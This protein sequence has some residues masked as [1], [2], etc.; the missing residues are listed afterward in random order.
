MKR[1]FA[2]VLAA[3]FLV[4]TLCF[5]SCE[6]KENVHIDNEL[7]EK[8]GINID[9]SHM[10][11]Y[12]IR[13]LIPDELPEVKYGG[14]SYRILTSDSRIDELAVDTITGDSCNDEIFNRNLRI[15]NRFDLKLEIFE[16]MKPEEKIH[17]TVAAGTHDYQLVGLYNHLSYV[18]I[19]VKSVL[20]WCDIDAVDLD[21]PWHNKEANN[22]ATFNG[23]LYTICSDT[24]LTSMTYTF[25][26]FF[27]IDLA[28]TYGY[29]KREL[30]DLVNSGKWTF[31][32]F[33]E[34]TEQ[35]YY[36]TNG[37]GFRSPS[38]IYGFGYYMS[39]PCDVWLTAF[40]Q[41]IASKSDDGQLEIS[42]MR[43]KTVSI[44]DKLVDYHKN[45][46][47]YRRLNEKYQE[48]E[49]FMS[50]KICFAPLRFCAAYGVLRHMEN[51]YSILPFPK[52]DE[53][54]SRYYTNADDK[55]TVFAVPSS[56]YYDID[57]IGTV[58]EA[59]CAESYKK[60]YPVY[61]DGALKGRY[62][63]DST[64]AK[65]VDLIMDGRAFDFAFQFGDSCFMRLPYMVRDLMKE[66]SKGVAAKYRSVQFAIENQ[67][68]EIFKPIY[69]S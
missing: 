23:K 12:E 45:S 65:M 27:N 26:I 31:D 35:M 59:L 10:N 11:A 38:D 15:V 28:L 36:D 25:G 53:T 60:V 32:K 52:W 30:Y 43:E 2:F 33:C 55:F 48:E 57:R 56:E 34:I 40:G 51:T 1:F 46:I 3:A 17:A 18:P 54:Q 50:G 41:K 47:G 5:D 37:D 61:Y 68:N 14:E 44:V 29:Q 6:K 66:E 63:S 13:Q 8:Y 24:S 21:K 20:N 9:T 69:F 39:N 58:Y 67:I 4:A 62:S 19:T 64:T 49:E 16:D 42:F 7:N 22:G